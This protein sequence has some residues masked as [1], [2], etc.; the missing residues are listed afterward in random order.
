MGSRSRKA[1][2]ASKETVY[3]VVPKEEGWWVI[4]Q[5]GG[6]RQVFS[7]EEA[8]L[9]RACQ[10]CRQLAPSRVRVLDPSGSLVQEV[11]YTTVRPAPAAERHYA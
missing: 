7:E 5:Q 6:Y 10:I 9:Q 3:E 1:R 4:R 11:V 2:Q 8:A